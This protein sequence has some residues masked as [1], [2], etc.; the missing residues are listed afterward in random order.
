MKRI[1]LVMF[2]LLGVVAFSQDKQDENTEQKTEQ[3]VF[4]PKKG[5][6]TAAVKFGRGAT[7]GSSYAAPA[8]SSAVNGSYPTTEGY[9]DANNAGAMVSMA[10]LEGNYFITDKMAINLGIGLTFRTTPPA[11]NLPGVTSDDG[12]NLAPSYAA[13]VGEDKFDAYVTPG[14]HWYYKLKSPRLLPYVGFNIP[15]QYSRQSLFDPTVN[16]DTSTGSSAGATAINYGKS[17]YDLF[18][19]GLQGTAGLDYYLT[20]ELYIGLDVK[21]ISY[22]YVLSNKKPRPGALGRKSDNYTLSLFSQYFFKLGF[23]LN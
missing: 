10:G 21:P 15:M 19:I 12:M 5:T 9:V 2:S 1:F 13:V 8:N 16:V 23:R 14:V 4:S 3:S 18:V 6:I 11:V 17:H 20:Q 7:I 22:Y